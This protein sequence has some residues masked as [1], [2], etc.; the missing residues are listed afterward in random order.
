MS[1]PAGESAFVTGA[2]SGIGLGITRALIDGGAKVALTDIDGER[3]DEVARELTAGGAEV[4]TVVLD[5]S[6]PAGWAAAAD[7]A[8]AAIGPISILCNNAGVSGGGPIE[9]TTLDIWRWVQ[10]INIE[11]QF[12]GVATFLPRFRSRGGRAHILNTASMA[13]LVPITGQGAYVASKFASMGFS[14]VLRDEL[15]G[16]GIGVSVLCPGTVATRLGE[17]AAAQEAKV[18]GTELDIATAQRNTAM[19]AA[20]ADPDAVGRQVVEAMQAQQFLII[21]HREWAPLVERVHAEVD[22]TFSEFD[23]R[24]G[25]DTVA[26]ALIA[27]LPSTT[28]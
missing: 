28:R 13:A 7:Q 8:E 12:I 22:Q 14:L 1:W 6:D 20:G 26:Q 21:T 18:R 17:T 19:L 5:V 25:V 16:S 4:T 24:Y 3:L 23:G 27:P 15:A 10:K 9:Q 2:A 11:G